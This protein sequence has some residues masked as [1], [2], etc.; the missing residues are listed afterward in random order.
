MSVVDDLESALKDVYVAVQSFRKTVPSVL[1]NLMAWLQGVLDPMA[2]T[3]LPD[4]NSL[5]EFYTVLGLEADLLE[6]VTGDMG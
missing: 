6:L 3:D 1:L 4:Q 2:R 5:F